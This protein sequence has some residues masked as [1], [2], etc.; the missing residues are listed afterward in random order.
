MQL[1]LFD[2]VSIGIEYLENR[3]DD[4]LF[5][6]GAAAHIGTEILKQR[7]YSEA[8][9]YAEYAKRSNPIMISY[10]RGSEYNKRKQLDGVK[11]G[12]NAPA[13]TSV[14]VSEEFGVDEKT[15]RRDAKL[16]DA[17][18][19]IDEV[20]HEL[21]E[22]I[23]GGDS[24]LTK[25]DV[26]Q[27]SNLDEE[28]ILEVAK[29]KT[30]IAT[31]HTGDNESYTP[32]MYVDSA[33]KVMGSIDVDPASNDYAQSKINANKYFTESNSGLD[34]DWVGNV[35]IN[36]PYAYPLIGEFIDKLTSEYLNGNCE[37]AVLLTNNSADTKWFHKAGEYATAIC[38]TKGRINFYKADDSTTSPTNGQTFFYFGRD[39]EKF[40][41]EFKQYGMIVEVIENAS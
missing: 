36:P 9:I 12:H 3:S 11:V 5:N 15:I 2:D 25:K 32:L 24:G 21:K 7:G 33:R 8:D 17:I 39:K 37:S 14:L 20:S 28:A 1:V 22:E 41:N 16:A 19:H 13:R 29:G 6:L 40:A 26:I 30:V 4:E 23:I 10:I 27:V 38:F 18:D 31:L 35:W 34:K